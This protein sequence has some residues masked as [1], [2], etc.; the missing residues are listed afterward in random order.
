MAIPLSLL[1]LYTGEFSLVYAYGDW[2]NP[3]FLIS[4]VSSCLMGFVLNY[5]TML[6]S[7]VNSALTTTV[8][9][10]MKNVFITYIGMVLGGDYVYSNVNFV[11]VSISVLAGMMYSVFKFVHW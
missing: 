2:S 1:M 7:R 6:C 9:G 10:T 11:G 5:S 4:F 8:I 3:F